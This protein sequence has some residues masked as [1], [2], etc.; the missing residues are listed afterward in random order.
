ME[1]LFK[2]IPW[3]DHS[4]A[5]LLENEFFFPSANQLND[6]FDCLI[7]PTFGRATRGEMLDHLAEFIQHKNPKVSRER[8]YIAARKAYP[9]GKKKIF[10]GQRHRKSFLA[11]IQRDRNGH[12]GILSLTEDFT[13]VLMWTHYAKN[14]T[15]ICVGLDMTCLDSLIEEKAVGD[16]RIF[17]LRKKVVY[18]KQY[19]EWNWFKNPTHE[20]LE[21]IQ[22]TKSHSWSYEREH[23]ILLEINVRKEPVKSLV[24]KERIVYLPEGSI[25]QVLLGMNISPKDEA[26]IKRMLKKIDSRVVLKKAKRSANSF[27]IQF[28]R[29]PYR[30]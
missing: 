20:M 26:E 15:G 5:M 1:M 19:P 7:E 8:A 21:R 4:K 16:D 9:P 24:K 2:Y 14:H 28:A 27:D 25:R 29:V 22:I 13:N 6:P 18:A 11:K 3:N 23:R 12:F 17:F 30:V 10:P